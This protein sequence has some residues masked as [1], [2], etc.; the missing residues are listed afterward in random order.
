MKKM[1]TLSLVTLV[2]L[3]A[4]VVQAEPSNPGFESPLA[5]APP[6]NWTAF[7]GGDNP[8]SAT[9]GTIPGQAHSGTGYMDLGIEGQNSFAGIFQKLDTPVAPGDTVFLS[10][11]HKSLLD[12]FAAVR[13]LKLEWQGTP[14]PPQ[15]RVDTFTIGTSYEQFFLGGVAPAGTTGLVVTYAISSFTTGH[16]G[17]ANVY[18]DDFNVGIFH[19]PEPTTLTLAGMCLSGLGLLRRR[20][21]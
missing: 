20:R 7:S 19:V 17:A 12:P 21:S 14:N 4:S 2:A 1:L 6:T 13:E 11:W 15:T 10:G 5:P 16:T 18:V 9:R 8:A 3:A